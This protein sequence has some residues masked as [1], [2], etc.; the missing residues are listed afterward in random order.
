MLF[1]IGFMAAGKTSVGRAV[2]AATGRRFIDLDDAIAADGT[3]VAAL[4]A[5][6]EP[7]FRLREARALAQVIDAARGEPSVIATGGGAAAHGDNLARMRAAGLVVA[8][9]VEVAEAQRRASGDAGHTRPLLA[10]AHDLAQRRAPIY[11]RAHAVVDTTGRP[12]AAVL[13]DV[14]AVERAWQAAPHPSSTLLALG[15]RSYP[16]T[17]TDKLEPD[18][19]ARALG[20][21]SKLAVITDTNVA[22]HWSLEALAPAVTIAITPGEAHKTLATYQLICEQLVDAGLDRGSAIVAL[23]GGVVGDLAGF[24]AATL[25]RGI[26]VVQVPTTIVAMTDAAI[27]GKTAV[28]LPAGKNLVGAF[29]QPRLV[30]CALETLSTLPARERRAGF[31]E[32]W[33]Y[34]LLDGRE[35]WTDVVTCAGWAAGPASTPPPSELRGVIDRAIAYKAA[36]VGRDELERSGHRALL[37]LG[38]TVGHAIETA[39]GLLHGEAVGLGLI[40]ACRVSAAIAGLRPD[41]EHELVAALRASGLPADLDQHLAGPLADDIAARIQ[42]DKKRIG[43]NL[44]FIVIREVGVCEPV[45]LAV[46]ELRRILRPQ[47]AT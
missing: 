17:V 24:V 9:G 16:V 47:S 46:S 19:I 44:R 11:R 42:V 26:P 36:I 30:A 5:R 33:K 25:F 28:D 23:G 15:E 7:E 38:H 20:A 21:P 22:R 13:A 32:L 8:L 14:L 31:G 6:D 39:T 2:A 3:D 35:L 12:P 27:G 41:L 10:A 37:N 45:E 29:W 43:A 4:V 18:A 40:A 34:A 1:L